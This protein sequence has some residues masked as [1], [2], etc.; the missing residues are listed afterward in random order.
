MNWRARL[1]V[2]LAAYCASNFKE[3][4]TAKQTIDEILL[5]NT[6]LT[7]KEMKNLLNSVSARFAYM[8]GDKRIFENGVLATKWGL[9]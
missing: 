4:K 3:G 8:R 9:N 1:G 5:R 7:V 2:S 6:D